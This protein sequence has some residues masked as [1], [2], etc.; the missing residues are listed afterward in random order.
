MAK[1]VVAP[2]QGQLAELITEGENGFLYE[3]G[4]QTEMLDKIKKLLDDAGL[5]RQLG[6]AARKT[7]VENY[8]WN[9]NAQRALDACRYALSKHR[10]DLD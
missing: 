10:T 4:N 7:I 1:P 3:P 9:D 8:T 5:R 6:E 2:R